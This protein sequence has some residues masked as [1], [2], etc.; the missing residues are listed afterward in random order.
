MSFLLEIPAI[1]PSEV[2]DGDIG[3]DIIATPTSQPTAMSL[4]AFKLRLFRLSTN[5][6]R[7][8]KLDM[9]SLTRFD[10]A[11]AEEQRQWDLVYLHNGTPSIL[12]SSTYAHW[13][14]LQTYAHQLYLL[15]H[16]SFHHSR[17][18][19]FIASSREKCLKSSVALLDLHRQFYESPRLRHYRWLVH[20]MTSFNALHAAVALA[21]CVLDM[22]EQSDQA[23][24]L[25]IFNAAVLRIETL[26]TRSI[27][28]EKAFPILCHLR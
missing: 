21:S 1:M 20:G 14:I 15:I 16:Q 18:I 23:A 5:I 12:D 10:L 8:S 6:C 9:I 3:E 24:Y 26:Q 19:S 7:S 2:N 11:I 13:C 22:S 4:T 25:D 28:C 27:V 17:S